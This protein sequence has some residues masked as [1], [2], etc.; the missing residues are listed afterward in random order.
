ME[1][2]SSI[3]SV[4][5]LLELPVVRQA[6]YLELITTDAVHFRLLNPDPVFE[7][8]EMRLAQRDPETFKGFARVRRDIES[9][10][11]SATIQ[12]KIDSCC[13]RQYGWVDHRQ[14]L[15]STELEVWMDL[16][17]PN[18]WAVELYH[19]AIARDK[20]LVILQD[21]SFPKLFNKL[22]LQKNGFER[23]A[24]SATKGEVVAINLGAPHSKLN[25]TINLVP[26]VQNQ[27]PHPLSEGL[28]L[29]E[30]LANGVMI[31]DREDQVF[32]APAPRARYV[33]DLGYRLLGPTLILLLQSLKDQEGPVG[34]CGVG[35]GFLTTVA[36]SLQHAWPWLPEITAANK[37]KRCTSLLPNATSTQSL[38]PVAE[39]SNS[40]ISY[41]ACEPNHLLL[42]PMKAFVLAAM[43]G[44]L[45]ARL[46]A[47]AFA[48]V[49]HYARMTRGLYLPLP[50]ETILQQW[51]QQILSPKDDLITVISREGVLPGFKQTHLPWEA[52][53]LVKKGPWP[54]GSYLLTRGPIRTWVEVCA[55]QRSKAIE[56]WRNELEQRNRP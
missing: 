28:S 55:P 32:R 38:I 15:Y 16:S 50:V 46:Q 29:G 27:R 36:Q 8:I 22:M 33:H 6:R 7:M 42:P 31:K 52:K 19:K 10:M 1:E 40:L 26:T 21:T 30:K 18:P 25:G 23:I 51:R 11:G 5:E 37:A 17:Y 20:Q 3:Q 24:E 34:F 13:V 35:S 12:E 48:F 54:T 4:D 44:P 41:S 49:R 9:A 45:A 53:K 56:H 2:A 43:K 47:S 14:V 39:D